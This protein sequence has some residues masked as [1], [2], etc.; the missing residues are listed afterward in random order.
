MPAAWCRPAGGGSS[1]W[2]WPGSAPTPRDR[3]SRE[4][5]RLLDPAVR[6]RCGGDLPLGDPV[7]ARL[8]E[9]DPA[10]RRVRFTPV[11]PAAQVTDV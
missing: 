9:A 5:G 8:T 2:T 3:R 10:S 1:S 6:G 11:P 4:G 7:R